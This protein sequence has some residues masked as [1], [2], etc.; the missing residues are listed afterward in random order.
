MPLQTRLKIRAILFWAGLL[1]GL[2]AESHCWANDRVLVVYS[3]HQTYDWVQDIHNSIQ[4]A[5]GGLDVQLKA[6]YMDTKR[7]PTESWKRQAALK[8]K[9]LIRDFKPKVVIAVDD[10]AQSYLAKAYVGNPDLQVVFCAVN[11]RPEKYGYPASNVTGILERTY[12]AQTLKVLKMLMPSL[13]GIAVVTDDSATARIMRPHIVKRI[14]ELAPGINM[15]EYTAQDSF[16]N[17]KQVMTRLD[18][19]PRVDALLIPRYHTVRRD[20]AA[21]SVDSQEVMRWTP[22]PYRQ[23]GR[24]IVADHHRSWRAIGRDRRSA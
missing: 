17:W 23:T 6:F 8:A 14:S 24:G 10:N 22:L 18:R 12:P 13:G 16:S 7:N 15:V 3:Y 21:A 5:M 4:T 19:D 20:G 9:A 11:A 1:A 2:S